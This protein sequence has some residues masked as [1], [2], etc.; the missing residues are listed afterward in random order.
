MTADNWRDVATDP[1]P[2]SKRVLY[3]DAEGRVDVGSRR[4]LQYHRKPDRALPWE[5]GAYH[6]PIPAPVLWQPLPEPRKG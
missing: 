6:R 2:E 3:Q 4:D 5:G 1:P